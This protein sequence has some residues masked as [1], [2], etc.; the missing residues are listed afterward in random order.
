[1]LPGLEWSVEPDEDFGA[2]GGAEGG[3]RD[4]PPA[5]IRVDGVTSGALEAKVE[6]EGGGVGN[7][8]EQELRI[9]Q[10]AAHDLDALPLA[11][12]EVVH[13]AIRIDRQSIALGY[14]GDPPLQI[15]PLRGIVDA[16]RDV[17][18]GGQ[19][20]EEREM[21]EHDAD[22]EPAGKGRV[23]DLH[24]FSLPDDL[25]RVR[26]Q[27]AVDDVDER[28]LAGAVLAEERMDLARPHGKLDVVVCKA[29]GK[30]LD[31]AFEQ[32]PRRAGD[33]ALIH[34]CRAPASRDVAVSAISTGF[35]R[36]SPTT[37]RATS[38]RRG[39]G[40]E[41]DRGECGLA[42]DQAERPARCNRS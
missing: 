27:D 18:G 42:R 15:A 9:L 2:G 35:C 29:A 6:L 22:A 37:P 36:A 31:D 38:R 17:L 21:L 20:L 30:S 13:G 32:E 4:D 5:G 16:E 14:L 1:M 7:R 8:L 40:R 33:L 34:S 41:L 26:P 39:R 28:A 10:K 25:A 24:G 23:R 3:S 19:S 11:G 12:R